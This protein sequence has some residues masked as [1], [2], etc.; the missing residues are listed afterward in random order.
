[1]FSD[2]NDVLGIYAATCDAV[3]RCANGSGPVFIETVTA[4]WP[5]SQPLWPEPATGPTDLRM[6]WG[7]VEPAG[8]H[9]G[10]IAGH[11][12]VLR[13]ARELREEG[14]EWPEI[15]TIDARIGA[16]LDAA[17]HYA[18]ASPFPDPAGAAAGTFA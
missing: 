6:A 18:V 11:D 8:P 4:R 5:G 3:A 10:W 17:E 15:A 16:E 9:R 2:G 13:I 7:I 1:V 14:V 12:P